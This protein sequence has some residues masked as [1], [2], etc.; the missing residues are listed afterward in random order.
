MPSKVKRM[1]EEYQKGGLPR[2]GERFREHLSW[3][4]HNN[5]LYNKVRLLRL[6]RRYSG[7]DVDPLR[8]R[9]IEPSQ[10]VHIAGRLMEDEPRNTYHSEIPRISAE[11]YPGVILGGDWDRYPAKFETLSEYELFV[12]HFMEEIPW[13]ETSFFKRRVDQSI[14]EYWT[15]G[16]LFNKLQRFDRLYEDIRINGYKSQREIGGPPLEEITVLMGRENELL[17]YGNGR[18]RLIISKILELDRVPMLIL[19]YHRELLHPKRSTEI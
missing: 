1:K 16:G 12:Q 4:V 13:E 19:G 15:R 3:M 18:H 5:S 6:R 14:A 2:L 7:L 10:I 17:W 9:Y 8:L 11:V